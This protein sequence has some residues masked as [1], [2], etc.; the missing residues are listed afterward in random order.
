MIEEEFWETEFCPP[1]EM[2]MGPIFVSW[3]VMPLVMTV[4]HNKMLVWVWDALVQLSTNAPEKV[5]DSPKNQGSC[6]ACGR[7]RWSCGLLVLAIWVS[8]MVLGMQVFGPQC[9]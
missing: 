8:N 2:V 3:Q 4:S 7:P 5:E 6:H 1:T 9:T